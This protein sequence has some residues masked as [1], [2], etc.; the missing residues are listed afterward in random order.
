MILGGGYVGTINLPNVLNF[1]VS[2]SH[3]VWVMI[4]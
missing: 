2:I 3:G 1:H 4:N